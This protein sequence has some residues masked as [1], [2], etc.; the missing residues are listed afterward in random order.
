MSTA[1]LDIVAV[2]TNHIEQELSRIDR[3]RGLAKIIYAIFFVIGFSE[4]SRKNLVV[5]RAAHSACT[6]AC[7]DGKCGS[8]IYDNVRNIRNR[9]MILLDKVTAVH[10]PSF[11]KQ[12]VSDT[13]AE[14][15]DFA[16]DCTIN[17]DI[18]FR[19]SIA[20]IASRL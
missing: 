3:A 19:E 2:F 16:E 7:S 11:V 12:H 4:E 6:Q 18:E 17:G 5:L 1:T 14:W 10:L 8:I 9:M 15:D 13:V 20:A